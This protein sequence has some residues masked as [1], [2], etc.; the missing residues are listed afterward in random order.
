M[1][2]SD[3]NIVIVGK[4]PVIDFEVARIGFFG[5]FDRNGSVCVCRSCE[6]DHLGFCYLSFGPGDIENASNKQCEK[7]C[8][9]LHQI[10]I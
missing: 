5:P 3:L 6:L 4:I 1:C 7:A 10:Q 2:S 9:G 8:H